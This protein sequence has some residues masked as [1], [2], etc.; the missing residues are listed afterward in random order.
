M[1]RGNVHQALERVTQHFRD[2]G[3][4]YALIG[5]MALWAH[6][7]ERFTR[8]IHILTTRRGLDR[9]HSRLTGHG[10][11]PAFSGARKTFHDSESDVAIE[12][13]TTGEFPGDGTPLPV[14]FPDPRDAA[15]E[16]EGYSVIKLPKLIELKLASGLSAP[17]RLRDLSDVQDL[18]LILHLARDL[19]DQLDPSVRAEFYRMWEVAANVGGIVL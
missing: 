13:T 12:F 18:I 15:V 7:Y 8:D 9:I 11:V 1:K 14:A 5:A 2:E 4:D 6:G 10:Y 19:G 16:R 3:V 17:H